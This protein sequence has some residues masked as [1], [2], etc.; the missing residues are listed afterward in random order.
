MTMVSGFLVAKWMLPEELGYFNSFNII[1]SYI[2]LIQLG[3]PSGLSRELP[4]YMGKGEQERVKEFASVANYWSQV[5]GIFSLVT[6]FIVALYFILLNDF[7]LGFGIMTIGLSTFEAFY[8]T[9]YLKILY[10]SNTDFNKLSAISLVSSIVA[11][12][13]IYWVWKYGF[14]GLCMRA[15]GV[16]LV[17]W[18]LT[19]RW[20]PIKTKPNWSFANLKV[21]YKVGMPIYAVASMYGLWPTIQRTAILFMGGTKALGL[22]A[23]ATMVDGTLQTVTS[24]ISSI[25]FPKMSY[26]Y[27]QGKS[28]IELMKI[29]LKFVGISFL[30]YL[31][32][33]AIG[34]PVL[35]WV[36]EN[37]L[38]N[39]VGGIEAAQWMLIVSLISILSVFSNI[40][41]V[42]K[43]NFDRL[44]AY[45]A[46][47]II[48]A[49]ILFYFHYTA[50]FSLAIFPKALIAGYL[51][52]LLVDL[53]FYRNYYFAFEKGQH[54]N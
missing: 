18:I 15:A 49:I 14:Y 3:I 21:L 28:F 32:V 47:M 52:T 36:V 4:Y 46:G 6:S 26:A 23:L 44:K 38:P 33:L 51:A 42:I 34:W 43:K 10:R 35:P 1:T 41:M 7:K 50:E 54:L 11:F 5:L 9:K 13:G 19:Y 27:G 12:A 8:V 22:Y 40:Y 2:I 16:T 25:S 24:S 20:R 37:L 53:Y 31:F 48:W 17:N 39:Y 30:L 45:T 29:P